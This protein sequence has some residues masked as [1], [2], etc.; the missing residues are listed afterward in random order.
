MISKHKRETPHWA[1]NPYLGKICATEV[2]DKIVRIMTNTVVSESCAQS[3][4][5]VEQR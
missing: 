5:I 4:N 1:Y 2:E 3:N